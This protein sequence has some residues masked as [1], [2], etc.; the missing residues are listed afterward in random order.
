[1]GQIDIA[2]GKFV[3]NVSVA[4][5][6][7]A[8][9]NVI[10]KFFVELHLMVKNPETYFS[11]CQSMHAK[12]VIFHVEAVDDAQRVLSQMEPYDFQKGFA[13]KFQNVQFIFKIRGYCYRR[14]FVL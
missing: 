9:I 7:L 1:M 6:D 5:E 2:D 8:N 12:R 10:E 11:A 14:C 13:F 4:L 3:N